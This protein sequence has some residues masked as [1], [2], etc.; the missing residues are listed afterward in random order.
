[1]E[2]IAGVLGIEEGGKGLFHPGMDRQ[3]RGRRNRQK[4][5]DGRSI[6]LPT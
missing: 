5:K 4:D 1:M 6:V 3:G 2:K